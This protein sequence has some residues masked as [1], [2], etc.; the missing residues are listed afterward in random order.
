MNDREF[1]KHLQSIARGEEPAEREGQVLGQETQA[2]LEIAMISLSFCNTAGILLLLRLSQPERSRYSA[3]DL[4]TGIIK[5][6]A[7]ANSSW[8]GA[9]GL[10][11]PLPSA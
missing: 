8:P 3:K 2:Q 1:K 10:S 5:E 9:A 11:S 7:A 4:S 6:L